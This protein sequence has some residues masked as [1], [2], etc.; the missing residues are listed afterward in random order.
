MQF[1]NACDNALKTEISVKYD[2]LNGA[3]ILTLIQY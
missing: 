2:L 3:E 1:I